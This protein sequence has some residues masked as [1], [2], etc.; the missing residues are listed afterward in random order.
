[1]NADR[2]QLY[3]K[4]PIKGGNTSTSWEDMTIDIP[5]FE[6]YQGGPTPVAIATYGFYKYMHFDGKDETFTVTDLDGVDR[7]F[8]SKATGEGEEGA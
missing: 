1:M 5:G 6:I 4:E 7:D 2:N 3:Y 8:S